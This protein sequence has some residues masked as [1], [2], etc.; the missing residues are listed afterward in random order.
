MATLKDAKNQTLRIGPA[1]IREPQNLQPEKLAKEINK[2]NRRMSALTEKNKQ[3]N[4]AGQFRYKYAS[5]L[6][7]EVS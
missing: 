7:F 3:K 6:K 4:K 1:F 2:L 5:R